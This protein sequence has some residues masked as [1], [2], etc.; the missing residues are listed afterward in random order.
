MFC[1]EL[2]GRGRAI[3]ATAFLCKAVASPE[4]ADFHPDGLAEV[5]RTQQRCAKFFLADTQHGPWLV[6]DHDNPGSE[7]GR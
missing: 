5:F 4:N 1:D 2:R 7:A 3:R 6:S